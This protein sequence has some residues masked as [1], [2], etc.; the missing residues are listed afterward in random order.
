MTIS[1]IREQQKRER[2]LIRLRGQ[3]VA[4]AMF[5]YFRDV[6]TWE[7]ITNRHENQDGRSSGSLQP[8]HYIVMTDRLELASITHGHKVV[9]AQQ[10]VQPRFEV[11]VVA[12]HFYMRVPYDVEVETE[13]LGIAPHILAITPARLRRLE[14][15][16]QQDPMLYWLYKRYTRADEVKKKPKTIFDV[17]KKGVF[18]TNWSTHLDRQMIEA[19]GLAFLDAESEDEAEMDATHL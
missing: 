18:A 15:H 11:G 13:H 3:S 5:D 14:A 10:I 8:M 12:S 19:V 4:F 6:N 2:W 7:G 16:L 9:P 1:E 17:T